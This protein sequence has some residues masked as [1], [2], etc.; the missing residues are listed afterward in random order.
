M[1]KD[2]KDQPT[3]QKFHIHST[4]LSRVS[5]CVCKDCVIV[6]TFFLEKKIEVLPKK[7][8]MYVSEKGMI[9]WYIIAHCATRKK[10]LV[11]LGQIYVRTCR[12]RNG[13]RTGDA[14][15]LCNYGAGTKCL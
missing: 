10:G 6:G 3:K 4:K 11:A 12:V 15:V 1:T 9:M 14:D 7:I 13:Y 8:L 5:I 2:V